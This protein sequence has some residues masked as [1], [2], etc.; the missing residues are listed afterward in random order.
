MD[1][2]ATCSRGSAIRRPNARPTRCAT[3]TQ[4]SLRVLRQP[5]RHRLCAGQSAA[6]AASELE[7]ARRLGARR[8]RPQGAIRPRGVREL[9]REAARGVR[10]TRHRADLRRGVRRL[11][12]RA[13][14]RPGLFRGARRHGHLRQDRG[15]RASRR[16]AVRQAGLHAAVPG[17]SPGRHLLRPRHVQFASLRHGRDVR[18]PRA[19]GGPGCCDLFTTG[20]TT[21]GTRAARELNQRLESEHLAGAGRQSLD[22]LD[23]PLRAAVCATTGCFNIIFARPASP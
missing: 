21:R 10:A 23:D 9:A 7:R 13:G 14:R 12:A 22:D 18:I 2:G 3:W 16:R 1:G 4:A 20:S 11:Q 19:S 15:R 5:R 8:Q 17:G 6:G